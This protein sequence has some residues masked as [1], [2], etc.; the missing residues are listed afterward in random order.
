MWIRSK[1][2]Y[3]IVLL[4]LL[5][6]LFAD[7]HWLGRWMY[8]IHYKQMI[9]EQSRAHSVDPYLIAAIIR[10]ESNYKLDKTSEKGAVGLM[11]LMPQ[12]AQWITQRTRGEIS[13]VKQLQ[14]PMMNIRY[15]TWYVH[16]L[17]DQVVPKEATKEVEISLIAA[18]YNA[19]PGNVLKWSRQGV[20]DG[21]LMQSS[22]IPFGETRHYLNRVHYYYDKYVLHYPNMR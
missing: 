9:I 16:F 14:D 4:G 13:N 10:V 5:L 21:T 20:W 2:F 18:A 7:Q 3:V 17:S 15:G 19:G 11:Q 1:V 12:T 8:P 6:I 22:K